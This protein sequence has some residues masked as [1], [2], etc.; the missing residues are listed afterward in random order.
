MTGYPIPAT[1]LIPAAKPPIAQNQQET[2]LVD[3]VSASIVIGGALGAEAFLELAGVIADEGLATEW[4][5]EPFDPE[6]RTAGEPLRLYAHE[7]AWGRFE[8]L[9]AWCVEHALPFARW[10]G[11][12]S[13]QWG[14]ER[15]V[16]TGSGEPTSY[17][18]DEDDDVVIGRE[19]VQRLGSIEA[20][21]AQFDAADFE[22]PQ[23]TIGDEDSRLAAPLNDEKLR[24]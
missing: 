19:A 6:H 10:S 18:V 2:P 20:V 15:V 4:D 22:V 24:A 14:A 16:F 8:R 23:L 7:V 21:I 13:G 9:E 17:A 5:G 3:R 1:R 11:A 12:Y